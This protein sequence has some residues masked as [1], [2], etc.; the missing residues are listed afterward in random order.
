MNACMIRHTIAAILFNQAM[1]VVAP[2][3]VTPMDPRVSRAKYM[4]KE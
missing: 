4:D 2:L 1:M 3:F